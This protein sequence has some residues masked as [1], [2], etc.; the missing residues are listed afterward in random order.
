LIVAVAA[1]RPSGTARA[2]VGV[3]WAN[4]ALAPVMRTSALATEDG[5]TMVLFGPAADS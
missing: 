2:A 4:G 1:E 5:D 3:T